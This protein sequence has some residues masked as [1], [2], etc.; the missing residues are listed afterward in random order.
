MKDAVK[1]EKKQA[2]NKKDQDIDSIESIDEDEI[3]QQEK[4]FVHSLTP[5]IKPVAPEKKY[6]HVPFGSDKPCTHIK[7]PFEDQ[8]RRHYNSVLL[9]KIHN[10][11]VCILHLNLLLFLVYLKRAAPNLV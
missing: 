4:V 1:E 8:R 7:F 2:K 6:F 10:I 11:L 5:P 9:N 3:Y